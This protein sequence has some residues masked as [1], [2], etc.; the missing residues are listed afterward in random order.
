MAKLTADEQRPVYLA[1]AKSAVESTH[2]GACVFCALC[3]W[4][5]VARC[6]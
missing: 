5:Q 2:E 6:P 4:P 1:E 3:S